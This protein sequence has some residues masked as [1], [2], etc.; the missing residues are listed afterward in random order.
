MYSEYLILWVST[1]VPLK[2]HIASCFSEA[3]TWGLLSGQ[4][5]EA[6]RTG[7]WGAHAAEGDASLFWLNQYKY[8]QL[9]ARTYLN[10]SN[11]ALLSTSL[12]SLRL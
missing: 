7:R 11:S 4:L 6:P 3:P 10:K 1:N 12:Q 8:F 5:L 2:Q 9:G